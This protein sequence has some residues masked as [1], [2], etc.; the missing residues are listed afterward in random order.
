MNVYVESNFVLELALQQ[1]QS[2]SCQELIHLGE[3]G[4]ITLNVPAYCLAEPYETLARRRK[5]RHQ[6]KRNVDDALR[7]LERT[8]VYAEHVGRLES[9]TALLISSADEEKV[10]LDRVVAKIIDVS[11]VIPLKPGIMRESIGDQRR[12]DFSP[13][14]AIVYASVAS[15]LRARSSGDQSC[16]LNRNSKDFDDQNVVDELNRWRCKLLTRFDDG[17]SFVRSRLTGQSAS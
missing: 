8:R 13:Q 12:Y 10:R 15:H 16:F 14:D 4:Q 3:R 9:L 11:D 5:E 1:E 17:L 6:L 7:Q 2:T